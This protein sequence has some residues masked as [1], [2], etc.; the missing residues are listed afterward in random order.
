[1]GPKAEGHDD[2]LHR[3]R[4]SRQVMYGNGEYISMEAVGLWGPLL[5]FNTAFAWKEKGPCRH[6]ML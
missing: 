4:Q 5:V 6:S 2:D 1:M 3:C